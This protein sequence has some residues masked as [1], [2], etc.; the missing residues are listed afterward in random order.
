MKTL[1]TNNGLQNRRVPDNYQP[2]PE[3]ALVDSFLN[4]A[5]LD[6]VF[7]NRQAALA[8]IQKDS[9]INNLKQ[10]LAALDLYMSRG[11]E[12]LISA[13]NFD[14]TTLPQIQ[15]DRLAQKTALRQQINDLNQN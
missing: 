2:G 9:Q 14:V 13:Q 12:D 8:Q 11:L 7:P 10:Q 3:E 15:Q 4:D 1:Y 5:D 6:E